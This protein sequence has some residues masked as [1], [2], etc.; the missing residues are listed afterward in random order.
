M[1]QNNENTERNDRTNNAQNQ[2]RPNRI[3]SVPVPC[4]C[5]REERSERTRSPE[6]HNVLSYSFWC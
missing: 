1:K 2:Q 4:L 6:Q 5:P 3:Q